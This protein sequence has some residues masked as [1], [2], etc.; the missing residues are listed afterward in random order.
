MVVEFG[1]YDH[2][3]HV[4]FFFIYFPWVCLT[5]IIFLFFLYFFFGGVRGALGNA[6]KF[7]LCISCFFLNFY[8]CFDLI[9]ISFS[10]FSYFSCIFGESFIIFFHYHYRFFDSTSKVTF[11][12]CIFF[13]SCLSK[14]YE[15]PHILTSFNFNLTP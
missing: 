3:P 14:R 5:V 4:F 8:P 1:Q 7:G 12:L 11:P 9:F 2:E 15:L 10:H 13:F 6:A